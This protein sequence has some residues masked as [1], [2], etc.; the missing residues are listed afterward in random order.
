MN[1][2]CPRKAIA[3]I[4]FLTFYSGVVL[5]Q[6]C[7]EYK[8]CIFPFFLF[9]QRYPSSPTPKYVFSFLSRHF[10]IAGAVPSVAPSPSQE[11][12]PLPSPTLEA[13][14]RRVQFGLIQPVPKP[15]KFHPS[16]KFAASFT[17]A[18]SHPDSA[19]HVTPPPCPT[20]QGSTRAMIYALDSPSCNHCA[21]CKAHFFF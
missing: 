10:P 12:L 5:P 2:W 17:P 1:L 20:P 7:E 15:A 21:F 19:P 13:Q 8:P 3:C 16:P 6:R 14:R 18:T 11:F 4:V 9:P